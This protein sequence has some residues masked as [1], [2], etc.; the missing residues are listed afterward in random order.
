V[1]SSIAELLSRR[2]GL[3][4]ESLSPRVLE[5]AVRERMERV[6]TKDQGVY[7]DLAVESPSEFQALVD[8]IA[9]PETWFFR[10]REPFLFLA[11]WAREAV[12]NRPK[13]RFRVLSC[14]CSTGEEAYS[15]AMTLLR[16]GL[17]AGQIL[18]DGADVCQRA[19][20]T[21]LAGRYGSGSFRE[22]DLDFDAFFV[23]QDDRWSV[24]D[25]VRS[26]VRFFRANL[27][28]AAAFRTNAPYDAIFCRNL[29]IY[30]TPEARCA[31]AVN[32]D[33][34]LAP[35][36][37]VFLGY[38]EP[39]RTF[40]PDYRS[41]DHP[42]AYAAVKPEVETPR[43]TVKPAG[44][45]DGKPSAPRPRWVPSKPG[46]SEGGRTT[47]GASTDSAPA[48]TRAKRLAD[49]GQLAQAAEICREKLE[50]DPGSAEA[51]YLLGVIALAENREEAAARHLDRTLYL[52]PDHLDALVHMGL[53]MDRQGRTDMA[54][55]YR[56]RMLRAQ[57][58]TESLGADR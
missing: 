6:G 38:A 24:D 17:P 11:D 52:S 22:K 35:G 29:M 13:R 39:R 33:R 25:R 8:L 55:R 56:Q 9:V 43:R 51:H 21:A 57:R 3:D 37:L 1:A 18:V 46:P 42:R 48:L 58:R 36:G 4:P 7:L 14:P 40:F 28:E 10:D 32:I 49:N 23:R 16:A 54:R 47:D 53:I 2:I 30:L 26:V 41:V 15:A 19:I 27:L 31:A 50:S 44:S 5:R 34:S 12:R 45:P 20:E